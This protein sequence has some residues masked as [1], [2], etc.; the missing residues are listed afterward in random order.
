M[1]INTFENLFTS[2]NILLSKHKKVNI[3]WFIF[4]III[5]NIFFFSYFKNTQRI[6]LI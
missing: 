4:H 2:L 5:L 3:F 1:H 6:L